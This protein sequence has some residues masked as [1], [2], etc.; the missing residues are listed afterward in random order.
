MY[1]LNVKAL[2]GV[3][4]NGWE[5]VS[6]DL[7]M[8]EIGDW[9]LIIK[10]ST[11]EAKFEVWSEDSSSKLRLIVKENYPHFNLHEGQIIILDDLIK[12]VIQVLNHAKPSVKSFSS[13]IE[14]LLDFSDDEVRSAYNSW[15]KGDCSRSGLVKILLEQVQKEDDKYDYNK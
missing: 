12:F 13:K 15:D 7:E 9:L 2:K 6:V 5:V 14:E 4:V 8:D 11:T 3:V 1:S 10:T